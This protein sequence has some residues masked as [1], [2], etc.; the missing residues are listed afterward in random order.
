MAVK[1]QEVRRASGV[2]VWLCGLSVLLMG[3]NVMA[4]KTEAKPVCQSAQSRAFDFW[5]GE[6]QVTT[7][8]RPDW[9]ASS[10]ITLANN[11]CS[12][13]EA[14]QTPGGYAGT[15]V[16]F[17]D[18][19]RGEWH[20]TWIDN[21]GNPLYLKGKFKDGAMVLTDGK[22]EITWTPLPD[23]RVRQHWRNLQEADPA[24]QTLFDGYY[25]KL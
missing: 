22:N 19:G 4:E 13:N 8:A 2:V 9:V 11:G 5:L 20:Q 21:Q 10:K 12:I 25:R 14:Y 15:S 3:G 6:W 7:P 24:K 18:A 23:G 16:N 17:Y 1:W